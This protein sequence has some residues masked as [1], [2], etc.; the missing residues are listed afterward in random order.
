A[1]FEQMDFDSITVAPYMGQDSVS[2]FLEYQNRW[3]I[4]LA[5]TSNVGAEDFQFEELHNSKK[6]YQLVL[7][8]SQAWGN[9][10]NMMFVV[11]AT[12]PA[13]FSE[14][15]KIVPQHFLLVPGYGA[16]GGSL[17]EVAKY[18]MNKDC[19]LLVN[20]SRAILY[21]GQ[22]VDFAEKAALKSA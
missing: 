12:R 1:F 10:N 4:L 13:L 15:R 8:K 2:P 14:I 7:E 18:G 22:N 19:G 5:A 21:A 9:E 11:G 20:S 3:V 6:L 16:Q 17:A